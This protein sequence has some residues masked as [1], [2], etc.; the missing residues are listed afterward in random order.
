MAV[1]RSIVGAAALVAAS[2][3]LSVAAACARSPSPTSLDDDMIVIPAGWFTMGRDRGPADEGPARRFF[4]D[5]YAIDRTEVTNLQY[6]RFVLAT[7]R[8]APRYWSGT[9]F[10][11][12]A[13]LEPVVGVG[14]ED[15]S[16][17][18]AWVDERLPTE[19]EW[20]K[21][22]RSSDAR[23]YPWGE[24]WDPSRANVATRLVGDAD[25]AWEP[26][27]RPRSWLPSG[28]RPVGTC[29][30]DVSPLGVRDLAGNA[31][32]WVADW[33]SWSGYAGWP[34]RNPIGQGPEWNRSIRGGA[35]L[36]LASSA[37]PSD[38]ARCSARNSSHSYDDPRVGFRCAR[39]L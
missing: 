16:A 13:G 38:L 36:V 39:S 1:R 30:R 33:Y 6:R 37:E 15:A 27:A 24:A 23:A 4:L 14:W 25:E 21:A 18:C 32:E 29:S 5:A 12:G 34:D 7:G 10:P 17:Y 26:L 9:S 3:V 28:L 8:A 11:P 35:W 19:A 31:A 20:E 2:A 22:C